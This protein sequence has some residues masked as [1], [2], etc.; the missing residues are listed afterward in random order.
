M[1]INMIYVLYIDGKPYKAYKQLAHLKS[2][3]R[4]KMNST[5]LIEY[6]EIDDSVYDVLDIRNLFP[7]VCPL[8]GRVPTEYD[9]KYD[10]KYYHAASCPE[11]PN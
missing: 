5:R 9:L 2:A 8:C 7:Q 4:L 11:S 3:A 10:R 6:K 1:V